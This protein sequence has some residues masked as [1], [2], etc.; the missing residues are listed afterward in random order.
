MSLDVGERTASLHRR[1]FGA[2]RADYEFTHLQQ[3]DQLVIDPEQLLTDW[4]E[5]PV[6]EL[7]PVGRAPEP[8]LGILEPP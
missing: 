3:R 7:L 8:Q 4:R 2:G 1:C 5:G 6:G